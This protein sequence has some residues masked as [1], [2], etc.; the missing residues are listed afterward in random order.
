[1]DTHIAKNP[2]FS[3]GKGK[4]RMN[5]NAGFSVERNHRYTQMDADLLHCIRVYLR[6]SAVKNL[7]ENFQEEPRLLRQPKEIIQ[8]IHLWYVIH[9]KTK[10]KRDAF[11]TEPGYE[12]R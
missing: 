12:F 1:V 6:S 2:G 11:F 7:R 5:M 3:A 8:R 9:P 4:N 10:S